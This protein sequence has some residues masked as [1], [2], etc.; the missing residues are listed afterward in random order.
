MRWIERTLGAVILALALNINALA[1]DPPD[2]VP[3]TPLAASLRQQGIFATYI[4]PLEQ[5]DRVLR[6]MTKDLPA[7]R[8]AALYAQLDRL[9]RHERLERHIYDHFDSDLWREFRPLWAEWAAR[10]VHADTLL[11]AAQLKPPAAVAPPSPERK[12]LL[13]RLASAIKLRDLLASEAS[14]LSRFVDECRDSLS[15][16]SAAVYQERSIYDAIPPEDQL[17]DS[18]MAPVVSKVSDDDLLADLAFAE[19]KA[20]DH[21]FGA[22]ATVGFGFDLKNMETIKKLLATAV[23]GL[24]SSSMYATSAEDKKKAAAIYAGVTRHSASPKPELPPSAA[25][26]ALTEAHRLD[27]KD[28]RILTEL[29]L[30]AT[31]VAQRAS[32]GDGIHQL[33]DADALAR[34]QKYLEQAIA[35]DPNIGNAF[36]YLGYIE[37]VRDN[38]DEADADYRKAETLRATTPWLRSNRADLD[39]ARGAYE[40]AA[41]TYR[42]ELADAS[43]S[44]GIANTAF[45]HLQLT[46]EKLNRPEMFLKAARAYV[47]ANPWAV[48]ERNALAFFV[49]SNDASNNGVDG[50]ESPLE[51]ALAKNDTTA[52]RALLKKGADPDTRASHWPQP[53]TLLWLAM[54]ADLRE[55]FELLLESGASPSIPPAAGPSMQDACRTGHFDPNKK[56][57]CDVIKAHEERHSKQ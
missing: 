11:R 25:F 15:A 17:V 55:A 57:A 14:S 2:I 47:A 4:K 35:I 8:R 43:S 30:F 7:D 18:Y 37:F 41:E 26:A 13:K 16:G 36:V 6:E 50:S 27:P 3:D 44:Y 20:G 51:Q 10:P 12:V 34:A 19:S 54:F 23:A 5:R 29:G 28:A 45:R 31:N 1:Q 22:L 21:Y 48:D 9:F 49:R 40:R 53:T 38:L 24:D 39:F 32:P 56:W 42:K 33:Y 52:M 46:A